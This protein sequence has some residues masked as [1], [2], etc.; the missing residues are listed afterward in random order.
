[1]VDDAIYKEHKSNI[2]ELLDIATDI[3][4]SSH[5][6][7]P[8]MQLPGLLSAVKEF[9]NEIFR[10]RTIISKWQEVELLSKCDMAIEKAYEAYKTL[11]AKVGNNLN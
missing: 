11:K 5:G 3:N 10:Y 7:I 9:N 4:E 2:D 6:N 1:M 8:L